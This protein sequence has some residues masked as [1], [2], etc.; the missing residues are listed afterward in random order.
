MDLP[1]LNL[2]AKGQKVQF[3][4]SLNFRKP[5]H[6]ELYNLA[7]GDKDL[8]TGDIDDLAVTNNGDTDKVLVTVVAALYFPEF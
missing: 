3:V 4:N 1:D 8:L 6:Q 2:L 5:P 7:F